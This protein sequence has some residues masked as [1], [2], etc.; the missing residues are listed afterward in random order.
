ML[1][2]NKKVVWK[3]TDCYLPWLKDKKEWKD[4]T[5][6]WEFTPEKNSIKIKMAHVGLVPGIECFENCREGWD[7]YIRDS[8]FYL[9]GKDNGKPD[10]ERIK[11]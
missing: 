1:I 3:I 9:L 10:R 11:R 8:L 2:I 6:V 4:T 7:F 5:V